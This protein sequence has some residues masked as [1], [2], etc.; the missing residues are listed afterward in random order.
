MCRNSRSVQR[1]AIKQTIVLG[2]GYNEKVVLN[3]INNYTMCLVHIYI[4]KD[5]INYLLL[6][7]MFLILKAVYNIKY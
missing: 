3:R 1:I 6:Y 7:L 2:S 4:Y 5:K